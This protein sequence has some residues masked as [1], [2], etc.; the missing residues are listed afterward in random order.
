MLGFIENFDDLLE[1]YIA[2]IFTN[3]NG[4]FE[5]QLNIHVTIGDILVAENI[6]NY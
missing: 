5:P 2:F 3:T 6:P 4:I 1:E